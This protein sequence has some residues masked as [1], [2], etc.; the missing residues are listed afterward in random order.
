MDQEGYLMDEE[1]FYLVNGKGEK[2]RLGDKE[3]SL[4]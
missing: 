2:I 4:L 1:S 3:I